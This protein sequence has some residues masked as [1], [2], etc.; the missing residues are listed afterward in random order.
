MLGGELFLKSKCFGDV[1]Y[2]SSNRD[3]GYAKG[4]EAMAQ[5]CEPLLEY[6]GTLL[7]SQQAFQRRCLEELKGQR[8]Q[9]RG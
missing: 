6:E 1:K 8:A 3:K 5:R 2:V 9:G 4:L 7:A